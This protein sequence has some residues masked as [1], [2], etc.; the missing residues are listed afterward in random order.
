[1]F[2]KRRDI[3]R[4]L[5]GNGYAVCMKGRRSSR[6]WAIL[7]LVVACGAYVA[8]RV[9]S[10][11][12]ELALQAEMKRLGDD[13]QQLREQLEQMKLTARHDEATRAELQS[14]L[15]DRSAQVKKLQD[16]LAFFRSQREKSGSASAAAR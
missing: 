1:M 10:G 11:S 4:T 8:W 13:N 12:P 7:L 6:G 15:D 9:E 3:T 5:S 2:R 16:E 14:Q